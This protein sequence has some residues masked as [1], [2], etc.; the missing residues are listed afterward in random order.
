MVCLLKSY[1][2]HV[3]VAHDLDSIDRTERR[4]YVWP[5]EVR[6]SSESKEG[7][8]FARLQSCNIK[9]DSGGVTIQLYPQAS[10]S[11]SLAQTI[12]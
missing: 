3:A 6:K 10:P 1:W 5:P 8:N 12:D 9:P 7:L 2:V 4:K 11:E